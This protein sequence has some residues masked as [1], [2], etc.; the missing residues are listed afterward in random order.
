M[1]LLKDAPYSVFIPWRT[2]CISYN[3]RRNPSWS[4]WIELPVLKTPTREIQSFRVYQTRF[5]FRSCLVCHK[6]E[7][8]HAFPQSLLP[9][10]QPKAAL[11]P[12]QKTRSP[13]CRPS[14]MAIALT[15]TVQV[16]TRISLQP[17]SPG[18]ARKTS[19]SESLHKVELYKYPGICFRKRQGLFRWLTVLVPYENFSPGTCKA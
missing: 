5:Q 9:T 17:S 14:M 10:K 1:Q 6:H 4:L 18:K 8:L 11:S 12:P 16:Q 19:F 15:A 3:C 7:V 13:T 2:N